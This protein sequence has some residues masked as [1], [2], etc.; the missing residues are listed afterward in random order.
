MKKFEIHLFSEKTSAGKVFRFSLGK[1]LWILAGTILATL[2]FFF[3]SPTE[4][5]NL[6]QDGQVVKVYKENQKLKQEIQTARETLDDSKKQLADSDSLLD[7]LFEG[8]ALKHIRAQAPMDSSLPVRP[9]N[10]VFVKNRYKKFLSV[11]D[12]SQKLAESLPIF[13][14][15]HGKR[16]ITNRY[17]IL[18]DPFTEQML[19]HRGIDFSAAV[20][21]TVYAPAQGVVA[22]V[23]THRGFGLSLK[24]E[25]TDHLKT[26]YAHLGEVFFSPGKVVSRGE[27]I[28]TVGK[29]GRTAG[30]AL[31]YEIRFDGHAINPEKYFLYPETRESKKSN[32]KP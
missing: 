17:Q 11:L 10:F 15:L 1:I 5:F 31:H 12:S 28:A 7:S 21:D 4:L 25:H 18:Y 13:R 29:S 9:E 30:P 6:L 14:P 19:P 16:T 22:E 24:L 27:P 26:F 32:E 2:G 3:F 23:K 20:G 8:K